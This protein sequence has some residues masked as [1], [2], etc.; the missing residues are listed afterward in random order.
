MAGFMGCG[1]TTVGLLLS[2]KLAWKFIDLDEQI[3]QAEG[4]TIAEMFARAGEA[5]F[6]KKEREVLGRILQETAQASGRVVALGGGTFAQPQNFELLERWGA[7]TIWL[8][9]PVEVLLLRCALMT[10]RPLFRD[11][12]SFRQ[13]YQERL[14]FYQRA[15]CTVHTGQSDPEE[16]VSQVLAAPALKGVVCRG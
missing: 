6:R 14:P 13:L 10:H 2:Q 11:E 3:E 15:A 9:C 5:A 12:A 16:V 1:K 8:E 7:T 4:A